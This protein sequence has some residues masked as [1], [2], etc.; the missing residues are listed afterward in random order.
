MNEQYGPPLKF[1]NVLGKGELR[2]GRMMIASIAIGVIMGGVI[3]SLAQQNIKLHETNLG[4]QQERVMYGFPNAEGIFIS[5]RK[6]P[7][8][9]ISAFVGEFVDNF[10]NF[11]PESAYTNVNAALRMMSPRMRAAEEELLR[12]S[13]KQSVEQQITQVF[14]R[15]G[16]VTVEMDPKA[17]G[18]VASFRAARYRATLSTVFNTSRFDVKFLIKPVKPSKHFEWAVVI[19]DK[20]V[21]EITK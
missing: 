12:A 20:Q 9:H 8:R 7:D 6:I 10:Y 1:F 5:E 21:Q 16:P 18:Y 13:A 19:D 3:Y 4:L 11:A 15:T 2:A 14:V 17:G